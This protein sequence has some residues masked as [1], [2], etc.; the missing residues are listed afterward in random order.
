MCICHI[1]AVAVFKLCYFIKMTLE[2]FR[3]QVHPGLLQDLITGEFEEQFWKA[4]VGSNTGSDNSA[5][6]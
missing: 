5:L 4:F 6:K 3:I 1:N 2:H